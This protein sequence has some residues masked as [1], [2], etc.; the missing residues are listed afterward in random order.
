MV[1]QHE[2]VML[3]DSLQ[4]LSA[5]SPEER[6]KSIQAYI[7]QK[8]L[9]EKLA[10]EKEEKMQLRREENQAM[11]GQAGPQIIGG[12][13]QGAWYFYNPSLVRSGQTEFQSRWGRRKLEDNWRR[14]N[15]TAVLF[16]EDVAAAQDSVDVV[17]SDSILLDENGNPLEKVALQQEGD[18]PDE[19]NP[20]FYLRQIPETEE[21]IEHSNLLWS[22]ALFSMGKIYKD[23][24]EDY[25][26]SL[27]TFDE[28]MERFANY[29]LVPEALYQSYLISMKLGQKAEAEQYRM[30]L[31]ENYPDVQYAELLS[32]RFHRDQ[33]ADVRRTGFSVQDGLRGFQ[34]E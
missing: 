4:R 14:A 13:L 8:E 19:K 33:A 32:Q 31:I 18:I 22:E 23:K 2:I 12:N 26:L 17:P 5:K 15:K 11:A 21:Q 7:A 28:Y 3:Q 1:V 16:E 6:L 10:A 24:L 27:K 30:R 34:P 25:S 29:E 20:E 9:E